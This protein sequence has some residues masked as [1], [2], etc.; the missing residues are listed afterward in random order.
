MVRSEHEHVCFVQIVST[1]ADLENKAN[2]LTGAVTLFIF[3]SEKGKNVC[4]STFL[5]RI[6]QVHISYSNESTRIMSVYTN[7]S[8]VNVV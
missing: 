7:N 6:S 5:V 1:N 4:L 3:F 8:F 2:I